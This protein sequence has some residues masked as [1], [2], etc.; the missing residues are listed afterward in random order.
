M[1]TIYTSLRARHRHKIVL[2]QP[3][4]PRSEVFAG[5]AGITLLQ[6]AARDFVQEDS[7]RSEAPEQ[8]K[9]ARR[10]I[11]IGAGF[12]GLCAA[13][14][15][16]GLGY[17]V[18]VYEARSRV[19]GRVQSLSNFVNGKIAEGGG[20]LIGSNHPLWNSYKHH[21]G[22]S[23]TD[24]RDYGNS[25]FRLKGE[26]LTA[27]QSKR[28][29]NEMEEQFKLL[30]NLAE[31][32]VDPF[33][34]WTNRNAH[35][36][37]HISV[38]HWISK[39]RCSDM[40]KHA[41]SVM[42]AADN[43]IPTGDQSLLAVLAMVKGGGLDR[44]WTDTELFRCKGGNQILGECFR[45]ALNKQ[46]NT[47]VEGAPVEMISSS[48]GKIRVTIKGKKD[49]E[50]DD[51]ILAIPPSVWHTLRIDGYPDLASKLVSPPQMGANVKYLMRI[52]SRFWQ[53]FAS[54][55][56]LSQ[57]GPVDLTWETTEDDKDGEFVMVAFSGSDDAGK[58]AGWTARQRKPNY[59][60]AMEAPYPG[61][62]TQIRGE[63][64]MN[65]LDEDWTKA[66]YYFP[67]VGEVTSWGP[68]WKA[69]YGGWL[70]FAGEHTSY[71]FMG[72]MEGALSSGYRVARK[73][74]IRDNVFAA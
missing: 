22:L 72:Y 74:A 55:P 18:K 9:P 8:V 41:L 4:L 11:V 54:S 51:V 16:R 56:T 2:P 31:S 49:D 21:F 12:A 44:Y 37:D 27:D 23:F 25:P 7:Q 47:V 52:D 30:T 33:E 15:L 40:C 48:Q 64:F 70:H 65:W 20:E 43:G 1:P 61:L 38:G 69:G 46:P 58:C 63:R 14:E 34:P 17:D 10:V 13:Y 59:V 24:V 60:R 26:T 32:I 3:P 57:D 67:R 28:L 66:S 35:A 71:A 50:G 42:L 62:K 5:R 45:D 29:I 68:F 36:L 53:P 6:S 19:G 39:A 73:L